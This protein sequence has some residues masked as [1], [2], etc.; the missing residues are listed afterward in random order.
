MKK[1]LLTLILPLLAIGFFSSCDDVPAPYYVLNPEEAETTITGE[2]T[3]KV[4]YTVGDALTIINS[5]NYTSDKVYVKGIVVQIDEQGGSYGNATYY[6]ADS[7]NADGSVSSRLEVY[8]GFGLGGEKITEGYL[9]E[10]DFLIVYGQLTLYGSTPEVTQGSVLYQ[11]NEEIRPT[12]SEEEPSGEGTF[13]SPYNVAK[14]QQLISSGE[15]TSSNVYVKGIVSTIQDIG[16]SYGNAT[17]FISDDGSTAGQ[18]EVY[19]GYGLGGEKITSEDY[20]AVGDT[21]IVL[22][23]LTLYGSTA[24]ITQGSK[25]VY[26]NGDE[27]NPED[28]I[29]DP[30]GSGT[31]EDPY[32][33]AKAQQLIST[34]AYTSEN[35]YVKGKISQ[36]DDI[37]N[38]YGN[39]T[40]YIS[41]DGTTSGQLEVY[42]GYGLGG[43]RITSSDY[44][45]VG[46]D[47][48]VYGVLTLFYSTAE[49]TQ[50]SQLYMLNNE[51]SGGGGSTAEPVGSGSQTDPYNVA[52]AQQIISNKAYTSEKVYVK[53]KV[54][55]IDDIGNSYGNATYY[56][57]DD[58]TTAGQLEVYRGYGLGGE[59]IDSSTYLNIGDEVIVYGVLTLYYSTPEITQ[60]S[61]LYMLNGNT[62]GGGSEEPADPTGDGTLDN[63]YNAAAATQLANSLP[64]N[65]KTDNVVYIKGK[66]ATI[67]EQYGTQYGNAS[68]YISDDGTTS[69]TFYVYRALY[70]GNEK[71]TS[72]TLIAKGDDVIICGKLTKYVSS[73]GAT[74]ETVQNEAYLYSLNGE[75]GGGSEPPAP[76]DGEGDGSY[77]NPYNIAAVQSLYNSGATGTSCYTTGY[78]VGYIDGNSI[79]SGATFGIPSSSETEILIAASSSETDYTL[80]VPVQL[81]KGE[82]REGLDLF[83]NSDLLGA[84]ILVYGSIDKYFSV[85][86]I[87]SPS[88]VEAGSKTIGTKVSKRRR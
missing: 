86:G 78:I 57:S 3:A 26:L 34:G 10:G 71:Y 24:E 20:L 14:A 45:K 81:P 33:V 83:S 51:T 8:R 56:I 13:E 28:V 1:Y 16:T 77:D 29:G 12:E 23:Q 46:D 47:V 5:G 55:Q 52:K 61:Q 41:D 21:V 2:G 69:N 25:I 80:C 50:G 82:F 58:G 44:L 32:N 79:S 22:G 48:I 31:Q 75:T 36:I 72:G 67:K 27:N 85:C 18:L 11:L 19:R 84:K 17:Y 6:I 35:V 60:G 54:S 62:S 59:S 76:I 65:G 74:P 38:T 30:K 68:F 53:G 40:Y 64:D 88:Y 49:I 63:P 15:Y 39:A 43:A 73:Y 37:G 4:P 70:L 42:R 9:K 7:V 66:V 87:K